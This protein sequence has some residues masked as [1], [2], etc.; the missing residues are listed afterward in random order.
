MRI[1]RHLLIATPL[2]LLAAGCGT[3]STTETGELPVNNDDEGTVG[4]DGA[5]LAD[6]P[7]CG[8][9]GGVPDDGQDLPGADG[10][11]SGMT[12][13]GGL[14]IA[15]ALTRGPSDGTIAVQGIFFRDE[16]G[17]FLCDVIA[18]SLP[19]LCG[20]PRLALDGPVDEALGAPVQSAQG[21][22]WTNQA[23]TVFGTM[24]EGVLT[25]DALTTG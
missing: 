2:L 10:E 9:M 13:D 25:V 24:D 20:E 7:D 19:P 1:F 8:D 14:T 18:E 15:E 16:A 11:S 22:E 4:V 6:E 12:V 21:V 5:C 17:T 23:V 3:D